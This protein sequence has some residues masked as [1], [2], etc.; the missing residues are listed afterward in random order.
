MT[1]SQSVRILDLDPIRCLDGVTT[2][3]GEFMKGG[4]HMIPPNTREAAL[5]GVLLTSVVG[6]Q[7]AAV[8]VLV[9]VILLR[10]YGIAGSPV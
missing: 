8:I 2:M 3:P 6:L 7:A 9:G 10:W 4:D 5:W 1:Y